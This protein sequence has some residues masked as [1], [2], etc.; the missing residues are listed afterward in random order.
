MSPRVTSMSGGGSDGLREAAL[1]EPDL[2]AWG[3]EVGR[4]A[5]TKEVFVCLWG[6]LGAGKSTLAR[7]ACRGAGV[8]GPI[9]S[10]TFT[11]IN[12]YVDATGRPVYHVDLYRLRG[13]TDLPDVGWDDLLRADGA[14]FV[15]WPERAT[16]R[17][18]ADRWDIELRMMPDPDR[19]SVTVRRLGG[20]PAV[21]SFPAARQASR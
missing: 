18:P 13:P 16:G 3:R 11:L 9:P 2:E 5:T 17:L 10:P 15:E 7:A 8:R 21:P 6:E 20:S 4:L 12:R 19:R 14:V 1:S